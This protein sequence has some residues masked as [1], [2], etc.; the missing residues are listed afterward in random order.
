MNNLCVSA[1]FFFSLPTVWQWC[2]YKDE[3]A[4]HLVL[5]MQSI[6]PRL[7]YPLWFFISCF[8]PAPHMH[9]STFSHQ[10]ALSLGRALAASS[11]LVSGQLGANS[12]F[13]DA[14]AVEEYS[15]RIPFAC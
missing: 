13:K 14:P 11:L 1:L 2:A 12:W 4:Q 10:V 3:L 7:I 15:V 8:Q 5:Q 6:T 9:T